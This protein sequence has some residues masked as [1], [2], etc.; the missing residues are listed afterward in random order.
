MTGKYLPNYY[1]HYDIAYSNVD[2]Q[3]AGQRWSDLCDEIERVRVDGE[4]VL[5]HGGEHLEAPAA[6]SSLYIMHKYFTCY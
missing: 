4:V 1:Q 6:L 5:L 2:W 3:E